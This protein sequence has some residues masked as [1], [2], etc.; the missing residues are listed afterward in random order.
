MNVLLCTSYRIGKDYIKGGIAIWSNILL[1]YYREQKIAP[2]I[3]V[4]SYD[5]KDPKKPRLSESLPIRAIRGVLDY[6]MP[7][8]E[9]IHKLRSKKYD[10]LHL[11][12]SASISLFKDW[13]VVKIAKHYGAKTVLHFHFGRIPE[14]SIQKNWEWRLLLRVARIATEV[15][16]IDIKSYE[17]LKK[18]RVVNVHY[19]PNPLSQSIIKQVE[20]QRNVI[21]REGNKACFVGQVIPTKG[22][23][24]L[25]EAFRDIHN[26]S[27]Y[28]IGKGTPEIKREMIRLS[29]ESKT[30]HFLDE[31]DH[32]EVIKELLSSE[33]FI[34]PTF[35]EGFPNV[36]LESMA[37][38]C[39]IVTTPVGAIPEMLDL[40]SKEP[41]GLCSQPKDINGLKK[42]IL[43]F[44][45]NPAKARE[46]GNR[47]SVRVNEMYAM[48]MVWNELLKIWNG[49][50]S[51][52][53]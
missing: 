42:N 38:G 39:A 32:T 44:I 25:A 47:A 28:V 12:T 48:P 1:D 36:I 41:C 30:I 51:G 10:V 18:N 16:T 19:L 22:V 52:K 11:C 31:I 9:T 34:L 20:N 4:V 5:R 50:N 17:T 6:K 40:D 27:L 2:I 49:I 23:F 8:K 33:L 46:Y 29:G 35:T 26:I 3:D 45:N 53:D 14:L 21:K 7:V 15:I 43:Y 13:V 24:E 37:C